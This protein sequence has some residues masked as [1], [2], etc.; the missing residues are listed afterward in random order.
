MQLRHI[1]IN[2]DRRRNLTSSMMQQF[3]LLSNIKLDCQNYRDVDVALDDLR[4]GVDL[5]NSHLQKHITATL[6]LKPV[7]SYQLS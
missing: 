2:Y 7:I 3:K 5:M 1:I 4:M 6:T